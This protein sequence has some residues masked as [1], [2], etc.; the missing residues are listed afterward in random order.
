MRF[1]STFKYANSVFTSISKT[2]SIKK[3]RLRLVFL[4]ALELGNAGKVLSLVFELL[5]DVFL[6]GNV[7]LLL[8]KTLVSPALA[9]NYLLVITIHVKNDLV[10]YRLILIL[11][12]YCVIVD[13]IECNSDH[14]CHVN[15]TCNDIPGSY[16]CNCLEG[17]TGN[18]TYCDGM[19]SYLVHLLDVIDLFFRRVRLQCL[20]F[21]RQL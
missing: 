4:K 7:T 5:H 1:R 17:F 10:N 16:E 6:V 8:T 3:A 21:R 2:S 18:G 13:I 15:A 19:Y 12:K 9:P 20:H 11:K 14:P